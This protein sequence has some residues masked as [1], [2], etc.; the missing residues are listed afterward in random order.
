MNETNVTVKLDGLGAMTAY[1]RLR[2]AAGQWSLV[3]FPRG[4]VT[5]SRSL[6]N[7]GAVENIWTYENG[8]WVQ[9]PKFLV[10]GQGYWIKPR[11]DGTLADINNTLFTKVVYPETNLKDYDINSSDILEKIGSVAADTWAL[12]G[13]D[14]NITITDIY[15]NIN[16]ACYGVLTYYYYTDANESNSGWNNNP[17]GDFAGQIPENSGFWIKPVNCDQ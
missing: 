11:K 5:T 17:G 13:T 12:L 6:L 4:Y 2:F 1:N 3:A 14:T 9:F 16:P 10:P 8:K 15:K 7:T